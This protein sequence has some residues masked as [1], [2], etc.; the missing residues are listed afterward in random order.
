MLAAVTFSAAVSATGTARADAFDSVRVEL[1]DVAERSRA[2]HELVEHAAPAVRRDAERIV[3]AVDRKRASLSARIDLLE[4]VGEPSEQLERPKLE[5]KS[6]L[7]FLD[8]LLGI[9][10]RWFGR[11]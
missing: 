11:R 8:H 3:A 6:T 10:E 5:M 4:L 2:L 1:E 9:V 7:R